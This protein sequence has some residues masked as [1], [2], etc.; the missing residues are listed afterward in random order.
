MRCK[1]AIKNIS[2]AMDSRLEP[3]AEQALRQHLQACPACRAWQHEQSWLQE[4]V[5][6]PR[7]VQPAP[8]FFAGLQDRINKSQARPR[9][10]A[11]SPFSLRPVLLRAAMFLILLFSAAFGFFLGGRLEAPAANTADAAFDQAMNL[12]AFADAPAGSFASVYERLLQGE[13]R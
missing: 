2:L 5:K 12:D 7:A 9:L 11:F 8:G 10:F 4:L 1:K 13:L 3:T 6:T